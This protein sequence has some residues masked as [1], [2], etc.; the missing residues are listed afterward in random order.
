MS[1]KYEYIAGSRIS[2]RRA[3]EETSRNRL[4]DGG[5][6]ERLDIFPRESETYALLDSV[7]G[8]RN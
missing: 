5:I 3:M 8:G 1:A 7:A 6:L 4:H 2:R